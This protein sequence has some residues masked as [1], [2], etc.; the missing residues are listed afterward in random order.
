MSWISSILVWVVF[1]TLL[2]VV[3]WVYRSVSLSGTLQPRVGKDSAPP[4]GQHAK[5]A[6]VMTHYAVFNSKDEWGKGT[7]CKDT[8]LLVFLHGIGGH[9]E[10]LTW[11]VD[12]GIAKALID[13]G[14]TILAI[15]LY[16]HG[17]T[18]APDISLGPNDFVSLVERVLEHLKVEHPFDLMG[19]SHGC[20]VSSAFT[21]ANPSKVRQ[22]VL[23]SPFGCYIPGHTWQVMAAFVAIIVHLT[24]EGNQSQLRTIYR[25]VKHLEGHRWPT[26][27][28]TI[29]STK[30]RLFLIAGSLE[31]DPALRCVQN[32]RAIHKAV[33]NSELHIYPNAGHMTW[34][35][36]SASAQ[37]DMRRLII[38]FLQDSSHG[39]PTDSKEEPLLGRK[40]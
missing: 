16:G 38:D 32:A 26:L 2:A 22:L 20:F 33:S 25:I 6:G 19:F 4:R 11:G 36:G 34:A 5:I 8:P 35:T 37:R 23:M 3:V 14:Y 1:P 28:K 31:A 9:L 30:M 15:D 29:D 39:A 27:S 24:F 13:A 12:G 7:I 18:E 21:A 10:Q 17:Y 40:A